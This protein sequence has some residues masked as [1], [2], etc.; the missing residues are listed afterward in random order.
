[1]RIDGV[2]HPF[3]TPAEAKPEEICSRIK[4]LSRLDIAEKR[5]PQDGRMEFSVEG[6]TAKKVDIRVSTLPTI[7]GEKVVLRLLDS[8]N[9]VFTLDALGYSPEE[10]RTVT[11][12]LQRPHGMVLVTGPTGSGKTASLYTFLSI[13]N[14]A[15]RNLCSVEDP[16][17]VYLQ[18][19]NQVG[20]N[21]K[22]GLSFANAMRAFLRQDPD[23]MMVGE[24][25]DTETAAIALKASQTGH[26]VLSTL[27]TNDAPS[28]IARLRSM[29]VAPYHLSDSINLISAQ[30]LLRKLCPHC[31]EE[32]KDEKG[33]LVLQNALQAGHIAKARSQVPT[34]ESSKPTFFKAHDP[35]CSHCHQ[36]FKGRLAI[37]QLM[38][39]TPNL[40]TLIVQSASSTEIESQAQE[41]GLRTLRELALDR[42]LAGQTSLREALLHT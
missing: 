15:E 12:A 24:I 30:R 33:F 6:K 22:A 11:H 27:H 31:K 1:M 3:P 36:G 19:V 5:L 32:E 34:T 26:I 41:Q 40:N 29:G 9:L 14:Q 23:V 37:F 7:D 17:E 42:V 20:V 8:S 38:P 25:R 2:L 10:Q 18:G 13:L 4:V 21:E 35:G 16:V 28:A 39:V